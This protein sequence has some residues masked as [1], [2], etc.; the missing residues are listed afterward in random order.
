[1]ASPNDY[2]NPYVGPRTYQLIES[3]FNRFHGRDVEASELLSTV[4]ANSLVLF[5]APSGAGK[6]SLI[7][8]RLIKSLIDEGFEVLP[9]GQVGGGTHKEIAHNGT[10]ESLAQNENPF[11]YNLCISMIKS[12]GALPDIKSLKLSDF[13]SGMINDEEGYTYDA[14]VV[15]VGREVNDG[16]SKKVLD[17]KVPQEEIRP[18]VLIIDQFEEILSTN[19]VFWKERPGFFVQLRKAMEEDPYLRVMLSLRADYV[20]GLDPY[21]HLLP[22]GMRTR[23]YMQELSHKAASKAI[24]GPA[25]N[26]GCDFEDNAVAELVKNLSKV[27]LPSSK[28]P[29]EGQFI[30]PLQLQVVCYKLW[31]KL[32]SN[33][34]SLSRIT[35]DDV[36]EAGNIENALSD[37]Y[38]DAILTVLEKSREYLEEDKVKPISENKLR[39]WFEHEL[40]IEDTETRNIVSKGSAET[41]G[42]ANRVVEILVE[43][44]LLRDFKRAEKI[45][46]ELA[47]DRF[48]EPILRANEA[49]RE[50]RRKS[51]LRKW[52]P[53]GSSAAALVIILITFVLSSAG[54]RQETIHAEKAATVIA[55]ELSEAEATSSIVSASAT[56]G[57]EQLFQA[58]TTA[59]IVSAA[60]TEGAVYLSEVEA[61]ATVTSAEAKRLSR[62]RPLKSGY[63]VGRAETIAGSIGAFVRDEKGDFFLLVPTLLLGYPECELGSPILQPSPLD[64]GQV[65]DDIIGYVTSC[66]PSADELPAANLIGLVRIEDGIEF[67]TIIPG[68]NL[69][70]GVRSPILGA[71]VQMLGRTSGLATGEITGVD[72]TVSIE[73]GQGKARKAR[74]TKAIITSPMALAGDM[75]ALVLDEEGFVI[76][77]IVAGSDQGT[78]LAP[79]QEILDGFGVHLMTALP[80]T[81]TAAD[82]STMIL[83]HGGSFEMGSDADVGFDICTIL[84][85]ENRCDR[86]FFEDEEPVHT[87]TLDDFYIDQ[88]EVTNSQ[89]AECVSAGECERPFSVSSR[90]DR[91]YYGNKLYDNYPVIYVRWYDAKAYCNWRGDRLPTEA[92][93]EKAARGTDGRVYP[94]GNTLMDGV[95]NFCDLN[96]LFDWRNKDYDDGNAGTAP[97]GAYPNSNIPY[98]I[99]DMAG[100]VFEW[101]ADWY[102]GDYYANSPSENP[103]GP[104]SGEYRVIRG[105]SFYHYGDFMRTTARWRMIPNET[106]GALGFRCASDALSLTDSR[107]F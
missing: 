42:L 89:Y 83:I 93:W 55:N 20:A 64:G 57:A 65:P 49:W 53:I 104:S 58:E 77:I 31:E 47:H 41:A 48:V 87:I 76:G 35:I 74:V 40:I 66:I 46:Y 102:S 2:D 26:A 75:G 86:T 30:S 84:R 50:A 22:E 67:E 71:S 80:S 70:R 43:Q 7:N 107:Q 39:D 92:E 103:Y 99:Y 52:L 59:T 95:A 81:F 68:V 63:S 60:A 16:E 51:L 45:W 91:I 61:T 8:A 33:K 5:Y 78:I 24:K 98:G 90:T 56:K 62:V 94:W 88:F 29:E 17:G 15:T 18:R 44:K 73:L 97:V 72:T 25:E 1:M 9:V 38:E 105:G 11:V 101:V 19:V 69:L 106:G 36:K 6:S 85:G 10:G 27:Y 13:L 82:D 32:S 21:A 23:Y 4:I 34:E 28:T 12:E 14:S 100:N 96:C 37:Y 54:P 3:D 79:I